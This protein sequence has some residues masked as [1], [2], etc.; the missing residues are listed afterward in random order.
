[1]LIDIDGVYMK[2]VDR[3]GAEVAGLCNV[4]RNTSLRVILRRMQR[5]RR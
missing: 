1:M 5:T 2:T 4:A 3:K